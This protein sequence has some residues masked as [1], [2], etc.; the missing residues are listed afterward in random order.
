MDI[1]ATGISLSCGKLNVFMKFKNSIIVAYFT[2][3]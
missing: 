2:T 3:A 1:K